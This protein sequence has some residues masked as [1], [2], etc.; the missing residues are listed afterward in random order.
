MA[1][2]VLNDRVLD[3]GLT[4][5]T[6]ADKILFCTQQ[7]TSYAEANTYSIGG[8]TVGAG[9]LLSSGPNP[10][11]PDGRK[12]TVANILGAVATGSGTPTDWA[13]VDSVNSRLLA[14]GP[15]TGAVPIV[16]PNIFNLSSFEINIPASLFIETEIHPITPAAPIILTTSPVS[17]PT[18]EFQVYGEWMAGD[19][20]T[21]ERKV[22]GTDW[23][24]ATVITRTLTAS[25]AAGTAI[26]LSLPALPEGFYAYRTKYKH[27]G[28]SYGPYSNT[29]T[30]LVSFNLV[31]TFIA[32]VILGG[33]TA[34]Y[35]GGG[36]AVYTSTV[37]IGTPYTNRR[38]MM[39]GIYVDKDS[40]N[41][42][43]SVKFNGVDV[44][45]TQTNNGVNL[46]WVAHAVVPTGTTLD[47]TVTYAFGAFNV[48]K[49]G[50]YHVDDSL[51]NSTV[52][53]AVQHVT[54]SG[55]NSRTFTLDTLAGGACVFQGILYG[56]TSVTLDLSSSTD[57]YVADQTS[58]AYHNR[59]ANNTLTRTTSLT[60]TWSNPDGEHYL[61]AWSFR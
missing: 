29:E 36:G 4:A 51:L 45:F 2:L 40:G 11:V 18:P 6:G 3:S 43:T 48:S 32:T 17:D 12:V 30:G 49:V 27:S 37:A 50:L 61:T 59:H 47:V 8:K 23:N 42:I 58:Y 44:P 57:K 31:M 53:Y 38:L 33:N 7:P 56:G 20:L 15:M 35:P 19:E 14:T 46:Y 16:P 39:F 13:I 10:R 41:T 24:T 34:L 28:G 22:Y 55:V 52:P 54:G 9:N 60:V 25:E 21:F 5:F 1:T 26:N